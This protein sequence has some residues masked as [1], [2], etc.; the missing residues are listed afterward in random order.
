[1]F[2]AE[3]RGDGADPWW[4]ED[5]GHNEGAHERLEFLSFGLGGSTFWFVGFGPAPPAGT[6]AL[7]LGMISSSGWWCRRFVN[8]SHCVARDA[9]IC[10]IRFVDVPVGGFCSNRCPNSLSCALFGCCFGLSCFLV[11]LWLLCCSCFG[12]FGLKLEP[13]AFCELPLDRNVASFEAFSAFWGVA[14]QL[15]QAISAFGRV[16][17]VIGSSLNR[18]ASEASRCEAV[19]LDV[20]SLDL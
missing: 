13:H 10:E 9:R 1:V 7:L 17:A 6:L 18:D 12:P 19:L 11:S 15:L 8:I 4:R 16:D 20:L 3:L 14:E 2:E 5:L